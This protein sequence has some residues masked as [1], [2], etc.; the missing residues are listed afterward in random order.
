MNEYQ[1]AKE[2]KRELSEKTQWLE[3]KLKEDAIEF[4]SSTT[5]MAVKGAVIGAGV[6]VGL[7]IAKALFSKKKQ[8]VVYEAAPGHH[9]SVPDQSS[10]HSVGHRLGAAIATVIIELGKQKVIEYI[11]KD[12]GQEKRDNEQPDQQS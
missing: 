12:N 6:L 10:G 11:N 1:K 9:A 4:K 8:K 7:T 5:K 2:L 3:S